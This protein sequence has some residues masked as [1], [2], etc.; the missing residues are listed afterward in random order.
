M[1]LNTEHAVPSMLKTMGEVGYSFYLTGSRRWKTNRPDSDWDFFVFDDDGELEHWL[2][3]VGFT[4][5]FVEQYVS[6]NNCSAVYEYID[7]VTGVVIQVQIVRDLK[8]KI[9]VQDVLL[10]KYPDGFGDK[11][12]AAEIWSDAFYYYSSFKGKLVG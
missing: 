12:R 9:H 2:M 6:N 8:A 5:N 10:A 3:T 11:E 1:L 7:Q 4:R